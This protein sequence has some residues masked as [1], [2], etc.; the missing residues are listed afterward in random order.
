MKIIKQVNNGRRG[1]LMG[2]STLDCKKMRI[3]LLFLLII[4][5]GGT[6]YAGHS[7]LDRVDSTFNPDIVANLYGIKIVNQVQALPDGKI[8]AIGNFTSYNRVPVGRVVRLNADGSLDPTFNTQAV[9]SFDA[10]GPATIS[11]QP[12]GKIVLMAWDIV[13]GGQGPK[14]MVRLNSDGSLDTSFNFTL[15][16]FVSGITIDSLGRILLNGNFSTPQGTRYIVRL[17][18]DGSMDNSFNYTSGTSS[19]S[20]LIAAQVNRLIVGSGNARIFRLNE[21]GSEDTSFTPTLTTG[22][23]LNALIVQPDNKI[24]YLMDRLRRLNENGSNDDTFQSPTA[25]NIGALKL[26]ADGKIVSAVGP[27]QATTFRRFL[28]NGTDDPSFNQY[29]H[30]AFKSYSIQ[31][32]G[33]IVI[34]DVS[35]PNHII[36]LNNFIRLRPADGVPDPTF[37]PGGIGFQIILAGSIRAIEPQPDGKILLGGKIDVVNG[38]NRYRLARL[39]ADATVDLSFEINT[40]V[41]GNYFSIIKDIY[42]IRAQSDGKIVVSGWFDYVL[43]GVAKRNMVRLNADGSI[44]TTFDLAH[45]MPDYSEIVGAGRNHFAILSDGKLMVGTSKNFTFELSGPTKLTTGGAVDTSFNP[46]IHS[47]SPQMYIDDVAIQPDGKI[48]I[49]GSHRAADMNSV[50]ISFVARLNADGSTDPTFVYSEEP[51]RLRTT[52]TLLP[53]GKILVGKHSNGTLFGRVE[54]LNPNGSPDASFNSLSIPNGIVNALLSLPNGKIFVGGRFTVLVNGQ[55]TSNLL[56]LD[57]DGNIEPTTYNVNEE[58]LSLAVDG[59]GRVLVGGSFTVIGANGAGANRSYVARLTDS[60]TLF[61]YDGDG[62]ADVSVYRPSNNYWFLSHSSDSQFSYHYF[63]APGDIPTPADFD[64]DGKTDLAIFRPSSGDWWYQSSISG[65]FIGKHWGS[66][67]D[68]PRPSDFDGDGKA[69]YIVYHP[70]NNYWYRLS[71]ATGQSSEVYF[72]TAGDKA[73]IGDF[74]GDGKSDPAIFRPST[75][76][77]WYQ[78]SIDS[79]HRAI[80][81]GTSTDVPVAADYDGDGKTDAAVYRPSNGY[82][83]IYLSGSGSYS[84]TNFGTSEDRPVAADYD[85]DGKADIA[86]YRPSNGTWYLQRSTGGFNAQEFGNSTDVPTPNTLVP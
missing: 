14:P 42:Q 47:Q 17:N 60:P 73:L 58:V 48:L 3:V 72:G 27:N 6:I 82:W 28:P 34:G 68:I 45:P 50:F 69:D 75:G 53:N 52:L 35:D 21:N 20:G 66:N 32:D 49:G 8:L 79:V 86:V 81:W 33:S 16:N 1:I 22:I 9:T 56:R 38:V 44:D 77:F 4:S 41:T 65:A 76:V 40:S 85:G 57:E 62:R 18:A 59:Q 63:G 61:D 80:V 71:S 15:S 43:G 29:T 55:Q 2:V 31:P 64:G 74:D 24:L 30:P 25:T 7:I 5:F 51:N 39:N 78:S 83:Y 12:D 11:L 67:S 70:S 54:R 84:F 36:P 23:Q 13:A 37:N 46:T 10:G 26:A 19:N